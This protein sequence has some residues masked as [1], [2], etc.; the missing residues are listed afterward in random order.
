ME[1]RLEAARGGD[2]RR[3]Y[4]KAGV[5]IMIKF[6]GIDMFGHRMVNTI[7]PNAHS[8]STQDGPQLIIVVRAMN[9]NIS[10]AL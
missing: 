5:Q 2:R 6:I 9:E 3:E 1:V 8:K 7:G 4:F 10:T